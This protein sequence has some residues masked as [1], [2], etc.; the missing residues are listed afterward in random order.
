V[1]DADLQACSPVA[2]H[3]LEARPG[4]RRIKLEDPF[5]HRIVV[6]AGVVPWKTVAA[7]DARTEDGSHSYRQTAIAR[8]HTLTGRRLLEI[9]AIGPPGGGALRFGF[10]GGAHIVLHNTK[11]VSRLVVEHER[12]HR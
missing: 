1:A 4:W 8:L 12:R 3:R 5:R 7:P 11:D 2:P 10:E 9:N 6:D